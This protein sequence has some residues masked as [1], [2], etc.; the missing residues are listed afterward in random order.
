M[1]NNSLERSKSSGEKAFPSKADK[2]ILSS[3]NYIDID[4]DID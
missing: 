2:T 1:S 3:S 4:I